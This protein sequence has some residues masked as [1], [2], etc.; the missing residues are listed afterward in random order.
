M[1]YRHFFTYSTHKETYPSS[2]ARLRVGRDIAGRSRPVPGPK[3]LLPW[4]QPIG[5]GWKCRTRSFLVVVSR[6]VFIGCYLIL[7]SFMVAK[8][9]NGDFDG[10]W[11]KVFWLLGVS[12]WVYGSN[13]GL[14]LWDDKDEMG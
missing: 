8:K 7:V 14:I 2:I 4:Q 5:G 3:R 10:S 11:L 13:G 1:L 6:A 12:W 9:T